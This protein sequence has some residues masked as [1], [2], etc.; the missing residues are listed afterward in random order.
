MTRD[1]AE[2][3]ALNILRSLLDY[4]P[5]KDDWTLTQDV[6]MLAGSLLDI[7][8]CSCF[9][10]TAMREGCAEPGDRCERK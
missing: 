8:T 4:R 10:C 6:K 1:Q 2:T 7:A 9:G 5:S 3:R